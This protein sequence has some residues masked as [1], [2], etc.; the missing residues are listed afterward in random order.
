MKARL[1]RPKLFLDERLANL[2]AESRF[3]LVGLLFLADRDGRMEDRP[4]KLRAQILPYGFGDGSPSLDAL[5]H[6]GLISRGEGFI[7]IEGFSDWVSPFRTEPQSL[8]P[9]DFQRSTPVEHGSY[10]VATASH[11]VA[12][13]KERREKGEERREKKES[14]FPIRDS[15]DP[16]LSDWYL[17]AV[18]A[19]PTRDE[20]HNSKSGGFESR[21]VQ[22]DS[23]Q[24]Q[25]NFH[26]L[27]ASGAVSA[28]ELYAC[29]W[30][31]ANHWR[32][33][34][35]TYNYIPNLSSF[36]SHGE[37]SPWCS[38]IED[39]RETIRQQDTEETA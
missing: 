15:K 4:L 32:K 19:Y 25:K 23:P 17:E 12:T 37:K 29:A 16:E 7:Q 36:F 27:L 6:G 9:K 22:R 33:A 31:A 14:L 5:E 13:V 30:L 35:D 1:I 18:Q 11:S 10:A 20:G 21:R 34:R 3:F 39:A 8:I 38:W 26:A 28:R 24:A 2:D